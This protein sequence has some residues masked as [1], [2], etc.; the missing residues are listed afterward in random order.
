MMIKQNN[1]LN[2]KKIYSTYQKNVKNKHN[3]RGKK[4][5]NVQEL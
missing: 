2:A 1:Y 4:F 5:N 3:T